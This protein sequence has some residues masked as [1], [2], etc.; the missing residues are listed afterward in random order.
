MS[1]K[2]TLIQAILATH[3]PGKLDELQSALAPLGWHLTG[4]AEH[5]L[6]APAETGTT[7]DAN[8][9]LK[10]QAAATATGLWALADDSGLEVAALGGQP[11]VMTADFGGWEKLLE[12]M[13]DVPDGQRQARF[14]CVLALVRPGADTLYF[15]GSCDGVISRNG[16][17]DGGFGYDPVFVPTGDTRTFADMN[18]ADKAG[19]SHRGK[20]VK[21]L[22]EWAHTYAWNGQ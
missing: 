15:M 19:F 1:E 20:A 17:G 8:A 9:L 6:P 21:A 3:N 4:L 16:S 5:G 10:A 22:L 13:R 18:K 2:T 7:F 11:G 14:I 12:V